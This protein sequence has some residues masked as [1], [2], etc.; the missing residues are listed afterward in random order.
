MRALGRFQ[1]AL[2]YRLNVRQDDGASIERQRAKESAP[3]SSM[4]DSIPCHNVQV[5]YPERL[6]RLVALL[7]VRG[8]PRLLYGMRRFLKTGRPYAL[9]SGLK[10]ELNVEDYFENMML[11]GKYQNALLVLLRRLLCPGAVAIDGGAHIGYLALHMAQIVGPVGKVYAFEPDPRAHARLVIAVKMNRMAGTVEPLD[12][13]LSS[14][15]GTVDF[16]LSP[17]LGWSTAVTESHLTNLTRTVVRS[18]SIDS[19]VNRGLIPSAVSLV[20]L[21]LEGFEVEAIRGMQRL[22]ATSK[23]FVMFEVNCSMLKARGESSEKLTQMFRS[24]GFQL[25]VI[26]SSSRRYGPADVPLH[27]IDQNP[28]GRDCDVLAVPDVRMEEI[29]G[30]VRL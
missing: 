20:K 12:L 22:L 9:K 25:Y 7:N 21:D 14:T 1:L 3:R 8:V 26:E 29:V 18:V 10:L 23:P 16:F 30:L 2:A 17:Q 11:W 27:R 24:L 15:D 5:S 13:A 4:T 28:I 19:L 6:G